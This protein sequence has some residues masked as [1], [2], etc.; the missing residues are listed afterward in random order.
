MSLDAERLYGLL[1][2]VVRLRDAAQGEPLRALIAAFATQFDALEENV[3]QLY[4]DQFI[5]TC[6]GWVVP[7]IGDL[8]GYRPLHGV[9]PRIASPRAEVANT[10]AM[11]RRKGT[12]SVLE[13]LAHDVTDWPAHAVEFFERLATTQYTKHVRL[14]APATLPVRDFGKMLR[15]GTPFD[16][17]AHTAEMRR[18]EAGSGRYNIPN[19]GIFLWRLKSLPL[20]AVPLT[21]DAGDASGRRFRVNPLGADLRLFRRPR[22]EPGID[23]LAEPVNVPDPLRVRELA[24]AARR[25]HPEDDYGPGRSI[26]LLDAGGTPL[27]PAT[28]RVADLRDILDAGGNVTGWNNEATIAAGT[29]GVDPERGRVLLGSRNDGPL[30][31]SFQYA[32]ARE[33]GG[34]QYNR[35]PEG[36]DFALQ[37]SVTGGVPLQPRLDAI[38]AGG[39]LLVGDSLTYA[40]TPV[41]KVADVFAPGAP[42]NR[43]VVAAGDGARPLIDA[44]GDI[45]LAIGARGHLVLDGLVIAGGTLR[46][47][48]AADDEPREIVLRDCTLVPGHALKPDGSPASPGAPSLVVDHP[49]ATVTLERCITGALRVVAGAQATITDSIVDAGGA[50]N[51]AY[52]A[53]GSGAHGAELQV[54]AST[55]VGTLATRLLRLGENSLFVGRIAAE[56]RQ[57]GCLRFSYVTPDSVTPR[58]YRCVP[59]DAHADML[60]H[61]TSLRYG[62][63][64]YG[65]LRRSTGAAIRE[66]ADNGGEM[67]VLN[68]LYQPQRETNLRIRLDEYLR[69]GLHAG[70]Y[71]VT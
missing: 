12:V 34:G 30:A 3:E 10:I 33:I 70:I 51:S 24:L 46:L 29:V 44:A 67:G 38:A 6:A 19:V 8:I 63:P 22:T 28:V 50:A 55:L 27:L 61:F 69:F 62:D 37:H 1:P 49:F 2:A 54:R 57:E 43:V 53:D 21:A 20:T 40:Q 18:P 42:G 14:H 32:Q 47:A 4:E 26:V 23:H 31:A 35:A 64:G 17:V 25:G 13:E 45:T 16:A 36:D 66:G 60:P 59:D 9:S 52:A 7:Y 15:Q 48:P 56:R 39:R 5:E 11:R 58:R 65:Q 71:Y 41:F 68:P